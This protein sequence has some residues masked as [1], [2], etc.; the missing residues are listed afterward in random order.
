MPRLQ[1]ERGTMKQSV[2][3]V[4]LSSYGSLYLY[5]GIATPS[6]RNDRVTLAVDSLSMIERVTPLPHRSAYVVA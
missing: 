1:A 3:G 4:S 6:A 2:S 5:S